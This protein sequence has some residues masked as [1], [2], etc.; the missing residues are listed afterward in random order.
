MSGAVEDLE[1][2]LRVGRQ[3]A[4]GTTLPRVE[5]RRAVE[6]AS[7]RDDE[8][9]EDGRRTLTERPGRIVQMSH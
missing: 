6:G 1:L 7:R 2:Y 5:A 8:E 9:G 3:I 4:D